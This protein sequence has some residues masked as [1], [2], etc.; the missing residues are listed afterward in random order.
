VFHFAVE[1]LGI[2]LRYRRSLVPPSK[3]VFREYERERGP[4]LYEAAEIRKLVKHGGSLR[5]MILLGINAAYGATD[6]CELRTSHIRDG[7]ATFPRPKTGVERKCKLWRET[8]AALNLTGLHVFN[9][10]PWN[11]SIIGHAFKSIC[12]THGIR[13]LGHYTLRR[14]F[15]TV[16]ST[17]S[18]SQSAID[19]CM[20]HS[21]DT[22]AD[23]YRQRV[24]D[25]QLEAIAEHVRAWYLG[26]IQLD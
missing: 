19:R 23:T 12:D 10:K 1:E 20:G 15:L 26:K 4:L 16:A 11:S 22:T 2:N 17:A 14:T 9:G 8:L 5:G 13:N 21:N 6:C 25:S 18:V 24:Y 3:R 7:W